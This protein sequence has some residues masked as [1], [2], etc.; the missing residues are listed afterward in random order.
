M[1]HEMEKPRTKLHE[2]RECASNV[3]NE[4]NE[5]RMNNEQDE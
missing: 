4:Q 3:L 1:F 5:H 2:G